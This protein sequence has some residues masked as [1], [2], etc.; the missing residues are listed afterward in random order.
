[1]QILRGEGGRG[2]GAVR[3]WQ[4]VRRSEYDTPQLMKLILFD[5]DGTLLW[6]DG[7]GRSAIR[8]A[9]MAEMGAAGPIEG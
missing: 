3:F 1:M 5:I 7:A 6:S 9:L 4:R 2:N 8:S